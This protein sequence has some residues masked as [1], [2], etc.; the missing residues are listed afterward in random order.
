M[1]TPALG[2]PIS[3]LPNEDGYRFIG[4]RH[5]LAQIQCR[6]LKGP[7]GLHR[8]VDLGGRSAYAS[9]RGWCPMR[10]AQ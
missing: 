7:D 3:A 4:F 2:Y 10:G 1:T 8:I 6:I 5:D 9:L